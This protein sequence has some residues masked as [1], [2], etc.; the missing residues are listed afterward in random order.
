M[1]RALSPSPLDRV[2]E[3]GKNGVLEELRNRQLDSKLGLDA[4]QDLKDRDR[5]AAQA[6]EIGIATGNVHLQY[7]LPE[8]RD[9]SF[10][11]APVYGFRR[12]R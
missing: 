7:V 2:R 1:T 12:A 5:I 10:E 4:V 3:P 8:M 11:R 6:E 9:A